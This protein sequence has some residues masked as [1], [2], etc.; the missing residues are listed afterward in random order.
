MR[1]ALLFE[2]ADCTEQIVT[3]PLQ[4]FELDSALLSQSACQGA[5]TRII[6]YQPGVTDEFQKFMPETP[7]WEK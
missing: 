2:V 4:K 7:P 5:F 1:D 3:K 6:D